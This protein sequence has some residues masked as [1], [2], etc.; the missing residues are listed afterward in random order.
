MNSNTQTK[1]EFKSRKKK[2]KTEKGNEEEGLA[3]G[4]ACSATRPSQQPASPASAQQQA[5]PRAR[6]GPAASRTPAR[7]PLRLTSLPAE[8]HPSVFPCSSS[9]R[10]AQPPAR[11]R[12]DSG[13]RGGPGGH[14]RGM[15]LLPHA[16]QSCNPTPPLD[17]LHVSPPHDTRRHWGHGARLYSQPARRSRPV[18]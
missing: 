8:P 11:P 6:A 3:A 15:A 7:P 2:K 10:H 12:A 5:G 17:A 13:G 4:S 1:F 16:P 18:P 14:A 9:P